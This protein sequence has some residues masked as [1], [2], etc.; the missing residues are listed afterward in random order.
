MKARFVN[1]DRSRIFFGEPVE[2][3]ADIK[4]RT[5]NVVGNP[6]NAFNLFSLDPLQRSSEPARRPRVG[7]FIAVLS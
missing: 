2:P 6:P 1:A 5:A 4:V 7:F 3:A